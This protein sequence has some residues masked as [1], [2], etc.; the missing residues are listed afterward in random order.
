MQIFPPGG[1]IGVSVSANKD[2]DS[3][4]PQELPFPLGLFCD[5]RSKDGSG[6]FG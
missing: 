3:L 6:S 4:L 5:G 1:G 2:A